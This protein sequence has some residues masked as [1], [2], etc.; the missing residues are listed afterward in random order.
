MQIYKQAIHS[1]TLRQTASVANALRF[2]TEQCLKFKH[3]LPVN[4]G[5]W[6]VNLLIQEA[7]FEFV[8]L[9]RKIHLDV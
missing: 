9:Q 2:P 1:S 6:S 4:C 5:S 7:A 3:T 8:T